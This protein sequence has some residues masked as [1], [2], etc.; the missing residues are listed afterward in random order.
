MLFSMHAGSRLGNANARAA[1]GL[2]CGGD[3]VTFEQRAVFLCTHKNLG[4]HACVHVKNPNTSSPHEPSHLNGT[5]FQPQIK[6]N[7]FVCVCVC[8]RARACVRV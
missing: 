2:L 5:P 4:M 3:M 8:V 6:T 1:G 7:G